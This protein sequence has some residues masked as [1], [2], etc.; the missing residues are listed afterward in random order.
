MGATTSVT[1]T[2][3]ECGH[4]TLDVFTRQRPTVAQL[5]AGR[6]VHVHPPS[7]L[8]NG[9]LD[10]GEIASCLRTGLITEQEFRSGRVVHQVDG[11]PTRAELLGWWGRD[12]TVH[13]PF[14]LVG[15]DEIGDGLYRLLEFKGMHAYRC[16][17]MKC[18][19]R[20]VIGYRDV[21]QA[22][23]RG[24]DSLAA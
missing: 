17:P 8:Y 10:A 23:N 14:G 2:C 4:R 12:P 24:C 15:P 1:L 22:F 9:V 6:F 5:I 21:E 11:P 20:T 16:H 7:D 18:G 13:R 3:A 19:H